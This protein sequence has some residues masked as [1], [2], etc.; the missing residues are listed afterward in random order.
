[1]ALARAFDTEWTT[2]CEV[3]VLKRSSDYAKEIIIESSRKIEDELVRA[4]GYWEKCT[5]VEEYRKCLKANG[6]SFIDVEF[7][8]TQ[9][10][11]QGLLDS[12]VE[13]RR[14]WKKSVLFGLDH[15]VKR[16]ELDDEW[17]ISTVKCIPK[18]MIRELFIS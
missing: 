16:G 7:S 15:G 18:H 3:R 11:V 17:F 5:N 6:K 9:E 12:V 1:V 2:E 10:A 14:P 13:W 4:R 8:P